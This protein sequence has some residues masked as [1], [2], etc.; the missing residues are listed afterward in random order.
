MIITF[1]DII[2][3]LFYVHKIYDKQT[4]TRKVVIF[5]NLSENKINA[6]QNRLLSSFVILCFSQEFT[7]HYAEVKEW[8]YFHENQGNSLTIPKN[9]KSIAR[10]R[11]NINSMEV[12]DRCIGYLVYMLSSFFH[13]NDLLTD[14]YYIFGRKLTY[15]KEQFE[16][17]TWESIIRDDFLFSI[18]LFGLDNIIDIQK[19]SKTSKDY[20]DN[21]ISTYRKYQSYYLETIAESELP[22]KNKFKN[23]LRAELA[24][25]QLTELYDNQYFDY[26]KEMSVE[27]I[28]KTKQIIWSLFALTVSPELV[29]EIHSD[30]ILRTQ[31]KKGIFTMDQAQDFLFP[32]SRNP[33]EYEKFEL[34][35]KKYHYINSSIVSSLK[36]IVSGMVL[37]PLPLP[38]A[39]EQHS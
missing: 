7:T 20:F 6:I 32:S 36:D 4:N 24:I 13:L 8:F 27:E 11:V 21:I 5:N 9:I 10:F 15:E 26:I 28:Q 33:D 19:N 14:F 12:P 29:D 3:N 39:P 23:E 37:S 17:Q 1:Q 34:E 38:F 22:V 25:G 35:N 2:D 30:S 18:L 31:I 16:K